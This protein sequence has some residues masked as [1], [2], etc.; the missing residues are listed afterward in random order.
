MMRDAMRRRILI[1]ARSMRQEFTAAE[2]AFAMRKFYTHNLV[3]SAQSVSRVIRD[4][5]KYERVGERR[6]KDVGH[7]GGG[8]YLPTYRVRR[9]A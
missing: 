3:E 7:R 2:L 9:K 4:S 6:V 1:T 5:S 8:N